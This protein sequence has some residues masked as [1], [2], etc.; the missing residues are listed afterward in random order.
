MLTGT[1]VP[2]VLLS[3]RGFLL[4]WWQGMG[5]RL[6]RKS[7]RMMYLFNTYLTLGDLGKAHGLPL[8]KRE[9]VM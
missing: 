3:Q 9:K 8:S 7:L 1:M 4:I 5:R 2:S 6:G